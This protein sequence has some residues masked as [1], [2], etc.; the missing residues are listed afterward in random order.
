[1][2]TDVGDAKLI[3]EGHAPVVRRADPE[4]LARAWQ[5]S[6][7]Q[8]VANIEEFDAAARQSIIDRYSPVAIASESLNSL[9]LSL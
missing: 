4:E 5:L 8:V 3:S 7:D 9:G 1:V 2:V 6:L